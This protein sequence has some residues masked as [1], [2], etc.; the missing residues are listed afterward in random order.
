MKKKMK[1]LIA[2]QLGIEAEGITEPCLI[3]VPITD[4]KGIQEVNRNFRE[5]NRCSFCP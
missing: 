1:E 4:A 5:V 2:D 3:S